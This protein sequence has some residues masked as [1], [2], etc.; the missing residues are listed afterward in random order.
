MRFYY[1]PKY[2]YTNRTIIDLTN[3]SSYKEKDYININ[4]QDY[5]NGNIIYQLEALENIPTY[6]HDIDNGKKWFVTGIS[7]LRT[8]KYQISLLRDLVSES[9]KWKTEEAYINAGTATDYNKY[10]TWSLPF[11]RTKVKEER[12]NIN[13]KSSFF[14]FYTNTQTIN[15]NE[16]TETDLNLKYESITGIS[17]IDYEV[18]KLED[19]HGYEYVNGN[20]YINWLSDESLVK[21]RFKGAWPGF[22]FDDRF[23][24]KYKNESITTYTPIYKSDSD[25]NN[26]VRIPSHIGY[27]ED[28]E[29]SFPNN[30]KADFGT[31][32]KNWT[33]TYR[34]TLGTTIN[35]AFINSL[36]TYV[37]KAIYDKDTSKIYKLSRNRVLKKYNTEFSKTSSETSTLRSAISQINYEILGEMPF[38]DDSVYFDGKWFVFQNECYEYEYSLEE[39]G[40][41]AS[42]DVNLTKD[43]RKLP[44]SAVRCVNIVPEENIDINDLS[45]ALMMIQANATNIDN[46]TG[47]I[48]DIQYLPFSVASEANEKIKINNNE[49]IAEFLDF[50]DYYYNIDLEDLTNINKETDSITI[51]SPSRATQYTFNPYNNDGNMEF[52]V[53]ITIKPYNSMIYVRP[54]TKGLLM[55]DFDDKNSMIISEDFS[56][57][58]LNSDWANYIYQNRNFEN[59][60]DRNIK[61]MEHTRSWERQVEQA[62]KLSDDW[63][64]R[65]IRAQ[66]VQTYSGNLPVISSIAGAV[67]AMTGPDQYYMQAA[68]KDREYNEAIYQESLS[69]A[70]DNFNYQLDNIKS[71]PIMPSKVTTIDAKF[72]DGVYLE[73]YS[74]NETELSAI[75]KYYYYNGNRI[76]DYGTFSKYYGNFIRGKII[77]SK[78]YNQPE[79]NELNR[80]LGLGIFT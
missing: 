33:N 78:E 41:V 51:V 8:G 60:F 50:D 32:I 20:K 2:K 10:K 6:V 58:K 14:V 9:D 5:V 47:K 3:D 55:Y 42:I 67:G 15:N 46:D 28:N 80:R 69:I 45:Q 4:T 11:T 24:Y 49:V 48:I 23:N 18:D 37:N 7:Q 1:N 16:I 70:R 35:T 34:Q 30:Q 68:Q 54:S 13:G 61:Q 19:I 29:P 56:L 36:D 38:T 52:S 79:I 66:K 59:L 63:T 25:I 44:K 12:L 64:G 75:E 17:Q 31:A 62:Q 22:P 40:T 57:T 72:L 71:Q 73:Y 21:I 43:V 27:W 65:N 26:Y 74:T 53:A 77:I 39:I 76:D